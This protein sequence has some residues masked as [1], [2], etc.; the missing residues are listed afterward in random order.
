VMG[1]ELALIYGFLY[2]TLQ[3][4]DYALVFGSAG[5]FAA[6]ATVMFTTRRVNWYE[7]R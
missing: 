7:A 2:I 3:L 5:L 6:L 1:L 4:Q